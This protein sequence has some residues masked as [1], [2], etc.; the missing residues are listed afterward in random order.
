M[1]KFYLTVAGKVCLVLSLVCVF[2]FSSQAQIRTYDTTF[3]GWNAI[4][5]E[6]LSLHGNDSAPGIV[7]FPGIG[8]QNKNI[9]DLRKN[10]PHYLIQH[11][12]WDG[13][14]PLGN[15]VHHPFI[16]SLQPP[17]WD[18]PAF[19]V[20]PKID[21]IL[22][23]YRIKRRAFYMTGLSLGAWQA[24]EF[25]TYQPSPG[26]RTYGNMVR[27]IVNLEGVEPADNTGIYASLA[28]PG[29]M[30]DWAKYCGGREL[31]IEGKNDW[32]DMLAGAQNM[33]NAVPNSATYFQVTYGGGAHCCWNSEYTPGVTW[34]KS[35]NANISQVVGNEVP[36]NVWQWLLRQGDT[37]MPSNAPVSPALVAA[38]PT[39]DAGQA[40]SVT[41]PTSSVTLNGNG[42]VSNGAK[43]SSMSWSQTGGPNSSKIKAGN[44][45]AS[46]V[47]GSL[48]ATASNMIEGDYTFQLTVKDDKGKAASAAVKV[49]VNKAP[50]PPVTAPKTSTPPPSAP[51]AATPPKVSGGPSKTITLPA[52]ASTLNGTA[53]GTNGAYVTTVQW[54]QSTGPVTA[55]IASISSLNTAVSGLTKS[56]TYGFRL[57]VTD[58]KGKKAAGVVNIV[59]KTAPA[60]APPAPSTPPTVSGGP[61]RTVD[62]PATTTTLNATAVGVNGAYVTTI[63]WEQSG[64]P[65]PAKILSP[66]SLNTGVSGLTKAGTYQFRVN[67]TDNRGKKAAGVVNVAV[68]AAVTKPATPN[69]PTEGNGN[70]AS[71]DV[72][73]GK[74]QVITLPES[75]TTIE[76]TATGKDGATIKGLAWK[77]VQGPIQT[78]LSSPGG[79]STSVSGLTEAGKYV[80]MLTATDNK[81]KTGN[82]SITITVEGGAKEPPTVSAGQSQTITLPTSAVTL[83][84]EAA[85][86]NG[87][88]VN[89]YFWNFVSGPSWVKFENEWAPSTTVSGLVAGTYVFTLSAS[90]NTG[91][92][93]VS[94]S[95]TVTVKPRP[96]NATTGST[97]TTGEAA[98]LAPD[99]V[100]SGAG[101]VIYP[102][103]VRDLLNIRLNNSVTG[104]I[105][106]AIFNTR[107]SRVASTELDKSSNN[108]ET[109]IDVSRLTPGI[110]VIQ[111]ISGPNV[112]TIEKFIKQ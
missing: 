17:S 48:S 6:D 78:T 109:S 85:G 82:A 14:V 5:T 69:P 43:V 36:M 4:V 99:S 111:V 10:G 112:T 110:Y 33:T 12:M 95:I 3:D 104:K 52:S 11:G 103:P 55:R 61:S 62:L 24:N 38:D 101:L 93:T 25:V 50:A 31:W 58:N 59:V 76:G 100:G 66:A 15:G 98:A 9:N 79:L 102:N 32:R 7:F 74:G 35:S 107:G 86:H 27:A 1:Q 13:S 89:S 51:S 80:Y 87:A 53:T 94:T 16:I 68:M 47:N 45:V 70:S 64:G 92:T 83:K 105:N 91:E 29:K 28:Y 67:V 30:G 34:T 90:D 56:G 42:K 39:A 96:S 84:G 71:P 8:E 23:R 77:Q 26:D 57:N 88:V 49:K 40:Q 37:S 106:V 97:A 81:G 60:A 46:G 41:L 44:T 108:L 21:A 72:T 75:S 73:T 19:N 20:K 65:A 18:N 2:S 22:R 54:E 63:Q